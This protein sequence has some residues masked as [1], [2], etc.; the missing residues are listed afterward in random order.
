MFNV[1]FNQKARSDQFVFSDNLSEALT[2]DFT[3][4]FLTKKDW[5]N[6]QYA[7]EYA[8]YNQAI[9]TAIQ[10]GVYTIEVDSQQKIVLL[11]KK[12]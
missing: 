3:Y 2:T 5:D 6:L 4:I 11:K 10:N 8:S 1:F 9:N 12:Q 7:P